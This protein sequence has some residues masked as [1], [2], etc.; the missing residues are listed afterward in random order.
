SSW[1]AAQAGYDMVIIGHA[2]LLASA[3]PLAQLRQ[4]QGLDVA[5][6]DVQDLYD[7]FNFGVKSPYALKSFLT[8]AN[9]K[10]QT[11]PHFV[12]LL[13]NGTFDPRDYLGTAVPD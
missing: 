11:K 2:S 7:E 5:L 9:A 13:G 4:S 8:T 6:I 1:H 12:L 3:A 10:W